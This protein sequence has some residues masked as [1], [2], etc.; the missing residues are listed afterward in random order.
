[1][2]VPH[3]P[4]WSPTVAIVMIVCNVLAIAIGRQV[5]KYPSEGPA[6]PAPALFGGMGLPALLGTTSLGH[7]LGAGAI[8]GLANIGVL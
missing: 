8:L 3:T 5:I 6:L 1:M 2:A 4:E 7:L